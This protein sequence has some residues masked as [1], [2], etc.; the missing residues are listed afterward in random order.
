MDEESKDTLI[1]QSEQTPERAEAYKSL[2]PK[3][4]SDTFKK[5]I[6]VSES[7]VEL[8]EPTDKIV[9]R[10]R[11]ALFVYRVLWFIYGVQIAIY[12]WVC[13]LNQF[14]VVW[15]DLFFF[16]MLSYWI[17]GVFAIFQWRTYL[18]LYCYILAIVDIGY[19]IIDFV[20][21]LTVIKSEQ[22]AP[23]QH[24]NL[25]IITSGLM[26]VLSVL[27]DISYL[28]AWNQQRMFVRK[29]P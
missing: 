2:T 6:P 7:K 21:V 28:I 5:K 13:S 26:L 12:V 27:F 16:L 25:L 23:N 24:F 10:R 11:R 17:L 3:S 4:G 20:L 18:V 9:E 1:E 14:K 19:K 15:E 8:V 29:F 22:A